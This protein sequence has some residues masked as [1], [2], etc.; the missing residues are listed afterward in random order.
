M[1]FSTFRR[2]SC[3]STGGGDSGPWYRFDPVNTCGIRPPAVA[4]FKC[5][6]SKDFGS[7][8]FVVNAVEPYWIV[9]AAPPPGPIWESQGDRGDVFVR[10]TQD[11]GSP[12]EPYIGLPLGFAYGA[13]SPEP[14]SAISSTTREV[15]C[16]LSGPGVVESG[17]SSPSAIERLTATGVQTSEE[18]ATR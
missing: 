16:W 4:P 18:F 14:R 11:Q 9:T 5:G 6:S 7:L 8:R 3:L 10:A 13:D 2:A 12:N 17:R 1:N 15:I